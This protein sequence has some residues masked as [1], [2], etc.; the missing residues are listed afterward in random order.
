MEEV[1]TTTGKIS[2]ISETSFSNGHMSR[3]FEDLDYDQDHHRV[4]RITVTSRTFPSDDIFEE[5]SEFI[6]S[7]E[8]ATSTIM[9]HVSVK[10]IRKNRLNSYLSVRLFTSVL[11]L[12]TSSD[13]ERWL[14]HWLA[15][16]NEGSILRS[17]N[18]RIDR[19]NITGRAKICKKKLQFNK[20]SGLW[21]RPKGYGDQLPSDG[22]RI[23]TMRINALNILSG[24]YDL[25]PSFRAFSDPTFACLAV[26]NH[27][28]ETTGYIPNR[29]ISKHFVNTKGEPDVQFSMLR[30]SSSEP[31]TFV[32][33]CKSI[34]Y[35]DVINLRFYVSEE[36]DNTL[37]DPRGTCIPVNSIAEYVAIT[38]L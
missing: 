35:P 27:N 8:N 1:T 9:E 4:G 10:Q 26:K 2:D 12:V 22:E 20:E 3:K 29:I 7:D 33:T 21:E 25:F 15:F 37:I 14:F 24:M 31:L 34:L 38:L 6:G 32:M 16:E 18:D 19:L 13:H 17:M 23:E 28:T 11:K 30:L 36:N 5:D